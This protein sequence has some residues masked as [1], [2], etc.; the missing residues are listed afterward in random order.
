MKEGITLYEKQADKK[1]KENTRKMEIKVMPN[2][3]ATSFKFY[4]VILNKKSNYFWH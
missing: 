4:S 2:T 3:N 1:E